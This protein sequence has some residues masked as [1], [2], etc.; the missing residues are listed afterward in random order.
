MTSKETKDLHFRVGREEDGLRLDRFLA[1]MMPSWSRSQ[2]Q[3]LVRRARVQVEGRDAQ[4]SG[5]AVLSEQKVVVEPV[6]E[7]FETY[8]E[9]LPLEILYEDTEVV[10]VNKPA[11]MVVHAGAGVK[12]GTLVN[13]LLYHLGGVSR[14]EDPA[15]PGIVHR[16]DKMTSGV[17]LVAKTDL[18]HRKLAEQFKSRDV[19]KLYLA[20][21]HGRMKDE[22]GEI[23]LS[24]GRD[25]RRR[26]RM[27]VGG[28]APREAVTTYEVLRRYEGFTFLRVQPRTGRTHQVRVHLASRGRPVVGDTLYGAPS[29]LRLAGKP[30]ATLAR[31]FLHAEEIH[32]R[33]PVT[34]VL[35]SCRAPLAL[36]LEDFL[37]ALESAAG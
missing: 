18:A 24:V 33:Q 29:R 14:G 15:R 17:L 32:F 12:S 23:R 19:T 3:R 5:Q 2:I 8:P 31:N 4:K 30:R 7:S 22:Q 16:L 11:G 10:V 26:V 27:R 9:D 21:V 20:L 28:I 34:G 6:R 36:E 25:R 37:R 1:L 35:M 13:A